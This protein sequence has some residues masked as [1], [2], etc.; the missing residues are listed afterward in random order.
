MNT[1]YI[2]HLNSLP[3]TI[4]RYHHPANSRACHVE[5]SAPPSTV[6]FPISVCSRWRRGPAGPAIRGPQLQAGRL[7]R[8]RR[9]HESVS[10]PRSGDSLPQWREWACGDAGLPRRRSS[11]CCVEYRRGLSW[12]EESGANQFRSQKSFVRKVGHEFWSPNLLISGFS[13]DSFSPSKPRRHSAISPAVHAALSTRGSLES[14]SRQP[15]CWRSSSANSCES[16]RGNE[17][18]T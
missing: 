2:A 9:V 11:S 12:T 7:H 18:S 1:H 17:V 13:P 3:V 8:V 15:T 10:A 5:C 16:L 14:I 4:H 6:Y